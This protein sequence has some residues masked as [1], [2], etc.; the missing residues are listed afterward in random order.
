MKKEEKEEFIEENSI[1]GH[2][3][4]VIKHWIF[5][6]DDGKPVGT[7]IPVSEEKEW[8]QFKKIANTLGLKVSDLF[9]IMI[10]QN[11]RD[12]ETIIPISSKMGYD[13]VD[14]YNETRDTLRA[15]IGNIDINLEKQS[16][17]VKDK[18]LDN[19]SSSVK[20]TIH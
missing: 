10:K 13:P 14:F 1:L 6:K 2:R 18:V 9:L 19:I 17:K 11:N 7:R 8:D 15:S 4:L 20:E 12:Y 5:G 3:G 16:S